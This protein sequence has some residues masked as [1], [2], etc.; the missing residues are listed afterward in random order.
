LS[1]KPRSIGGLLRAL[2]ACIVIVAV[3][4]V[5]FEVIYRYQLVDTYRPELRALNR[6]EDLAA[7]SKG[8][9]ILIMGDSFTASDRSYPAILRASL[10]QYRVINAGLTATGVLEATTIAPARFRKFKPSVFIYQIFVGNDLFN[11]RYPISWSRISLGRNIFWSMA[12]QLRSFGYLNYRAAQH[13]YYLKHRAM[14]APLIEPG[15]RSEKSDCDDESE[16][17]VDRYNES[18]RVYFQAEPRLLEDQ[19]LVRGARAQDYLI[20]LKRLGELLAYCDPATCDAYVLV[21]P[22]ACQVNAR[23]LHDM[24][25]LGAEFSAPQEVLADQYPF[26]EGIQKYLDAQGMTSVHVLS[27]IG[28]LRSNEADGSRVYYQNDPHLCARGQRLL[29]SYLLENLRLRQ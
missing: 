28:M 21:I 25:L 7:D 15:P 4:A 9:T 24:T 13:L 12:Q 22:H 17:S 18:E 26:L 2:L 6:P 10:P 20:L 29:A 11:I 14:G 5:L 16:F 19:V 23:Y 27:P 1:W 8:R 3:T